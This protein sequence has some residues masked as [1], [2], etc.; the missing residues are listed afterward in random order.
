MTD[1]SGPRKPGNF[2]GDSKNPAEGIL[3]EEHAVR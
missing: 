3:S 1:R 2:W